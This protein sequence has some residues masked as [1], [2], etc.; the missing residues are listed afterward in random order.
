M[1][2]VEPRAF[3]ALPTAMASFS[4]MPASLPPMKAPPNLPMLA[5]AT[6]A[7]VSSASVGSASTVRSAERPAMPKKIGMNRAVM[8]P[9][10]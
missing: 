9:R 6:S 4:D 7:S 3:I 8:T 5:M 1:T 10:S 2:S